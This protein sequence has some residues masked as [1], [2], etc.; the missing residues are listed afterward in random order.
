[1]N[2]LNGSLSGSGY[3]EKSVLSENPNIQFNLNVNDFD[4]KDTFDKFVTVKQFVPMAKYINGSFST[5]LKLNTKLDNTLMPIWDSFF[6]N[7]LLNLKTAEI[8]NFKPFTTVGSMLKMDALSNPKLQNVKPKYEIK[9]G[10]FYLSPMEY[11]I[12]NY[13]VVL[14]GSNGIDQTLDYVME[15]DV[16]AS[17]LKN[18]ANSA[19]TSL[20]GKDLNLITSNTIKVNAAIGGTIDNPKVKTSAADVAGG[21]VEQVTN[22]IVEEAKSQV[23]SLKIQAENKVKEEIKKKEEEAKKKLEEE[24]KKKLKK[25]F[26]FG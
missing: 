19:V 2:L 17:E 6:S 16:P 12:G 26:K 10:R 21:V 14:S 23:D 3:Y 20:V 15:I 8:K 13:N 24:A 18:K 4:I 25:L 7:G 5:S 22:K 11:K 9:N 1:M